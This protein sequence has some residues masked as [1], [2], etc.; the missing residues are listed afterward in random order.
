MSCVAKRSPDKF[1][2]SDPKGQRTS[3]GDTDSPRCEGGRGMIVSVRCDDT[4]LCLP[5]SPA[6][7]DA[8]LIFSFKGLVA[9]NGGPSAALL[10]SMPLNALHDCT[11][12]SIFA[13]RQILNTVN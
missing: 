9:V 11:C 5:G 2:C 4:R 3:V 7:R 8:R 12:H 13:Q 1:L 6:I 10:V